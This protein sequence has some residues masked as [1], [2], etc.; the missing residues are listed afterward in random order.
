MAPNK[1]L[2]AFATKIVEER[3]WRI[4]D[5]L[6]IWLH[7]QSG[8]TARANYADTVLKGMDEDFQ[9]NLRYFYSKEEID[10]A[11]KDFKL[12]LNT[13]GV[14]LLYIDYYTKQDMGKRIADVMAE[15]V[16]R[17]IVSEE[18][19]RAAFVFS[20]FYQGVSNPV[21]GLSSTDLEYLFKN[22]KGIYETIFVDETAL[23]DPEDYLRKIGI[24]LKVD[25]VPSKHPDS[26]KQLVA[27]EWSRDF[28]KKINNH[29]EVVPPKI[30]EKIKGYIDLLNE[31]NLIPQLMFYDL[32]LENDDYNRVP[33]TRD[34]TKVREELSLIYSK[35]IS[36]LPF[37]SGICGK[38]GSNI[39]LS[40]LAENQIRQALGEVKKN[41]IAPISEAIGKALRSLESE[42]KIFFGTGLISESPRVWAAHGLTSSLSIVTI[43]WCRSPKEAQSLRGLSQK[44]NHIVIFARD[45]GLQ[46]LQRLFGTDSRISFCLF[47]GTQIVYTP[48]ENEIFHMIIKEL[49]KDGKNAK[50]F[51]PE[52]E[53]SAE[54]GNIEYYSLPNDFRKFNDRLLEIFENSELNLKIVSPYIDETTFTDYISKVPKSVIVQI[55]TSNTG[56]ENR[57]R[58]EYDNLIR[59]GMLI[60]VKKL[61]LIDDEKQSEKESL[62]GRYLIIDNNYVIPSMPDLK[63]SYSGPQKGE[64]VEIER[65]AERIQIR[66]KDF[67]DYWAN[68]EEKLRLDISTTTW[69]P[70]LSRIPKE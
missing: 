45:Q 57:T 12:C 29:S 1:E 49:I 6:N 48:T 3:N 44:T 59:N 31:K 20:K 30:I 7:N 62:H 13:A 25:W 32:L 15:R 58:Q 21:Y 9:D 67:E 18:D 8:S 11:I 33:L 54:R 16:L 37:N 39:V 35:L 50:C 56:K 28:V 36:D 14:D 47:S 66:Q 68:P 51:A 46:V 38:V 5:C 10:Q 69:N 64:I 17:R 42:G 22:W 40:P 53:T 43:P 27:V 24:I 52:T 61:R 34:E 60:Y 4:L 26:S 19:K 63:R 65:S 70:K 23:L 41:R 55:I 2:L